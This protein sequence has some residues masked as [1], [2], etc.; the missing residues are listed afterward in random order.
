MVA[1]AGRVCVDRFETSLVDA[2]SGKAWSPFYPPD[3]ARATE[4]FVFYRDARERAPER[5]LDA[6]MPLPPVPTWSPKAKAVSAQNVLP[7]GY[8]N[9]DQAQAACQEAGKR[10]CTE[11]EWLTACRGEDNREFPYGATYEQGTCNV[12]R[13]NHPSA[14]LH[15][16]ASRY[17]DDPRN[18]LVV[19]EGKSLLQKTGAAPRCASRWGN[20]AIMDMVG[21][22]DEWVDDQNGVFVGGFYSRGTRAGCFSRIDAHPRGYS[23]YSTG[24]RCCADPIETTATVD[25]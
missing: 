20:D 5:S 14:L 12:Y 23:D 22:L 1:V 4:S 6:M 9:A 11:A 25:P 2:A 13:E 21:N 3:L 17:H 18:N 8:L 19:F 24:T 10:L 16:N 15:N 7:Q